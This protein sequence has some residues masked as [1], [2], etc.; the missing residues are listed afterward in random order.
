MK[1]E[2]TPLHIAA[3]H[4]HQSSLQILIQLGADVFLANVL[5]QLPFHVAVQNGHS[6]CVDLL[7]ILSTN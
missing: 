2:K 4:D 3:E 5:S 1:M 6:S 7:I